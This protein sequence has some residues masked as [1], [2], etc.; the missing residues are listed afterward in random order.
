[1]QQPE[2]SS[3]IGPKSSGLK[4]VFWCFIGLALLLA[5]G[6]IALV[7]TARPKPPLQL[8]VADGRIF[9]IEGVTY[10]KK[11]S[12][13]KPALIYE[14]FRPWLPN[15]LRQWLEPKH[16]KSTITT[17]RPALVV[18]VNALDPKSGTNIDC[19]GVRVEFIDSHGQIFGAE[20]SSWHGGQAFWRVGHIFYVY[21]RDESELNFQIVP[22]RTNVASNVRIQNPNPVRPARWNGKPLPQV[23]TNGDVE[24]ELTQLTIRTNGGP[25][26]S[27]GANSRNYYFE[28]YW[29]SPA[30]YFEPSW[31]FRKDGNEL[32]GW[33]EPEWIAEDPLGNRGRRL[34]I[35]QPV[36]RLVATVYP[37][38][39]NVAAAPAI[40]T[41]PPI[42]LSQLTTNVWWNTTCRAGTNA[43][44]AMGVCPAGVHVFMDGQYDTNSPSGMGPVH[45]G[46]RTGWTGQSWRA[47]PL[48]VK[49]KDGHYTPD[50]TIYIRA[51]DLTEPERLAVRL[52]D[53]EGKY[54]EAAPETQ[55]SPQGIHPF[56]L[57][58]PTN[59][60]TVVPEIV[61]LKPIEADFL[62]NTQP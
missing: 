56:M 33:T 5:V 20:T 60:T 17:D 30:A 51:P 24:L 42:N 26:Q 34:G 9:Q 41:L 62:V 53:S 55:G 48:Q 15:R 35:H 38:T 3:A 57:R 29:E 8:P 4:K 11:H 27:P 22:W 18:W 25:P 52:K 59:V 21:P 28:H 32:T 39:D 2:F 16:P 44:V 54:W 12:I 10:G 36:L 43:I 1:M 49:H 45:G 19:Q 6:F 46:A 58:V 13:G 37:K 50:A 23:K 7:W 14:H 31:K 40:A 61:L 47:T